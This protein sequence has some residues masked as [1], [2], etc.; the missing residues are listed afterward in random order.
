MS[1][2]DRVEGLPPGFRAA[3]STPNAAVAAMEDAGRRLYGIQFHPE[4][5]H[6]REGRTILRRFLFD[7]CGA[8]GDWTMASFVEKAIAEVRE[9]VGGERVLCAISGGVD[10]A[11][12]ALLIHRAV[13]DR[14]EL[15]FIDHGLLR[16]DEA[17]TVE[18]IFARTFHLKL[19]SV[20][21]GARF[22]KALKGLSDPEEKRKPS[23]RF[24]NPRPVRSATS[25][26]SPRGPS[27]RT[28]SNRR[29][30][31]ERPPSSR[32]TTTSAG[33]PSACACGSWN[34]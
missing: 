17:R 29:Q 23:S 22:F 26:F 25:R 24:S 9:T 6:T 7:V 31:P 21:A 5:T 34:R 30:R 15:L 4:V 12:M 11:V 28:A 10:S 14:L 16:K 3:G 33:S 2:G 8:K 32:A 19:R 27:T 13:G 18:H 1:H 20:D